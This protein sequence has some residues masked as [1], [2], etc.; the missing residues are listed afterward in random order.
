MQYPLILLVMLAGLLLGLLVGWFWFSKGK[1]ISAALQ[2]EINQKDRELQQINV[3]VI[4][5][6]STAKAMEAEAKAQ[7]REVLAQAKLEAQQ[8]EIKLEKDVARIEEKEKGLDTKVAEV[9]S[10]RKKLVDREKSME[11]METEL[12]EASQ[13]HRE[14]LEKVG[15]LTAEQAK[16]Q[17]KRQPL[18]FPT[19]K[20]DD[21]IKQISDWTPAKV[22]LLNYEAHPPIKADMALVGGL[23][24]EDWKNFAQS[25]KKGV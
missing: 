23:V 2:S 24:T 14:A 7:A 1:K 4:E 15:K 12:K 20:M 18:P 13:R 17:L 10:Q 16:E 22:E 11:Q 9:D 5:M 3:K 8:L 25:K 6:R 19:V 21:A